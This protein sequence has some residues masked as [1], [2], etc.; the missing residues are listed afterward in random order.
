MFSMARKDF[1]VTFAKSKKKVLVTLL[2]R[3]VR[4]W[5]C[6]YGFGR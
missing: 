4:K 6:D 1:L 5:W 2:E 3:N